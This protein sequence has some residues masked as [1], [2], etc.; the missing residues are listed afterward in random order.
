VQGLTEFLPVNGACE[1]AP[2]RLYHARVTVVLG[3]TDPLV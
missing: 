2:L 3:L 1:A